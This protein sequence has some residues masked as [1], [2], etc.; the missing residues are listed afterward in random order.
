VA[1]APRHPSGRY[2]V[3]ATQVSSSFGYIASSMHRQELR[4]AREVV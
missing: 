4:D 3:I 2:P 1:P